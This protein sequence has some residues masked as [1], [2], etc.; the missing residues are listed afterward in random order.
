MLTAVDSP[1][2]VSV[3]VITAQMLTQLTEMVGV[4]EGITVPLSMTVF[5]HV[6][7]YILY[8]RR[9]VV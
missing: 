8:A 1:L 2:N 7:R 5:C 3:V 9:N 4:P 6:D